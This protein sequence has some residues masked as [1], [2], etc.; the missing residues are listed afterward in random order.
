MWPHCPIFSDLSPRVL[1][2][3]APVPKLSSA[4]E[5]VWTSA[6][7]IRWVFVVQWWFNAFDWTVHVGES[8]V[9]IHMINTA[10]FVPGWLSF[11]INVPEFQM[12]FIQTIKHFFQKCLFHKWGFWSWPTHS[13][14]ALPSLLGSSCSKAQRPFVGRWGMKPRWSKGI[15]LWL[16]MLIWWLLVAN[17]NQLYLIN[18]SQ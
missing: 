14:W 3:L 10:L 18:S 17:D 11:Q 4:S 9:D 16:I 12:L 1:H 7:C 5:W 8:S 15:E 2:V 13:N 6:M